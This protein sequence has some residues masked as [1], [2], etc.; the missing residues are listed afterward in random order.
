MQDHPFQN[1]GAS[2][3]LC[4]VCDE[5]ITRH[6]FVATESAVI[7]VDPTNRTKSNSKE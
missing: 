1:N 5:P 6:E 2:S 7:R 4:I 3:G